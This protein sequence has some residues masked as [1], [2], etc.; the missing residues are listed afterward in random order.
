VGEPRL[1][2]GRTLYIIGLTIWYLEGKGGGSKG[3]SGGPPRLSGRDGE[4]RSEKKL[5]G[6][7]KVEKNNDLAELIKGRMPKKKRIRDGG[8]NGRNRG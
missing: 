5:S 1:V 8:K 2:R 4:T 7:G 6:R 3:V